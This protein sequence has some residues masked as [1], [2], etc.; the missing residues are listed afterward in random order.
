[1]WNRRL[2]CAA[3]IFIGSI[4]CAQEK[5]HVIKNGDTLFSLAKQYGVAIQDILFIN[6]IENPG[7][8]K[9]G[10]KI[11]IPKSDLMA[12]PINDVALVPYSIEY[13]AGKG[14]TLYGIARKHSIPLA[15]LR[16]ANNFSDTHVL[17]AGE[18]LKIPVHEPPP[19]VPAEPRHAAPPPR[20]G[21]LPRK[22]ETSV[23]SLIDDIT[24]RWPFNAKESAYISGKINPGMILTGEK[25]ETVRSV[26]SGT[27]VSAGPWRGFGRVV[28]IKSDSGYD[29]FYGGCESL[30]V[31]KGDRVAPGTEV[32][33]LGV[34]AL[35]A[36]PQLTF[37]VYFNQKWIDPAKAP[38]A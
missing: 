3:F 34:S 4:L 22:N 27:V 2:L 24:L 9:A 20:A 33:K 5:I 37:G 30:S 19:Q 17:K 28:I 12:T 1:M 31:R 36:K 35:T 18:T 14:E 7:K 32:G 13:T 38:R 25:S 15:A 21:P 6:G 8:I 11:R 10:Q 26:S 16:K 23:P 29:Y